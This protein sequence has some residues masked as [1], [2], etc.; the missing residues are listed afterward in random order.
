[1]VFFIKYNQNDQVQKDEVADHVV[2]MGQKPEGRRPLGTPRC[3][4]VD[5]IKMNL[6]EIGWGDLD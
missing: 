1:L 3:R 6:V 2:P 4:W 5:N